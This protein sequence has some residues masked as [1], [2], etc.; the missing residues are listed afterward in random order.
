MV[1]YIT[2][3]GEWVDHS[4]NSDTWIVWTVVITTMILLMICTA[5]FYKRW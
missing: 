1:G 3:E 5:F 2:K 4:I